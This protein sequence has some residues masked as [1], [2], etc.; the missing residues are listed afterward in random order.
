MSNETITLPVALMPREP[1]KR[2]WVTCAICEEDGMPAVWWD[3]D[4]GPYVTCMNVSCPSN[5][6]PDREA[7]A[8]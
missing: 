2:V 4:D 7:S 8:A 6:V 1:F 5:K 3:E